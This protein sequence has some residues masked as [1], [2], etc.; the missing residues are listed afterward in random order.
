M[1]E[2]TRVVVVGGFGV[3]VN[4]A[5]HDGAWPLPDVDTVFAH[6]GDLSLGHAGS[7]VALQAAA[8][9]CDVVGADVVGDD[10][11]G[12]FV[13]RELDRRGV[14]P[15]LVTDPSGTRRSVNLVRPDGRRLSLH[16]PRHPGGLTPDPDL[17][18]PLLDATAPAPGPE[19]VHVVIVDWARAALRDARER[20]LLTSTDLQDW[21]GRREHHRDF[22]YGADIVFCSGTN[23]SDPAALAEDVFARGVARA[24]VVTRGAAGAVVFARG[25][26]PL[27]VPAVTPQGRAIVDTNGAG[28]AFCAAF[29]TASVRG[30]DDA[31]AARRAAVAAAWSASFRG[32]N[33]HLITGADLDRLTPQGP[34]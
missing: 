20:G 27:H 18:R 10:E 13:R 17:W 12:R 28:D 8:L 22:A 19:W 29:M 33:E 25:R 30:A 34:A 21:D 6:V 15:V 32:T 4:V 31:Q 24:V 1:S 3:D 14:C 9:G 11:H 7:G 26:E 16:D 23:L 5:L 2:R